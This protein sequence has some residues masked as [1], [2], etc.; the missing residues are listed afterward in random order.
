MIAIRPNVMQ[1][2]HS[3]LYFDCVFINQIA[4]HKLTSFGILICWVVAGAW[5]LT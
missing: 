4:I 2:L 3:N 1:E 5:W